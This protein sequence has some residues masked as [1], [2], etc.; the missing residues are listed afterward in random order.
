MKMTALLYTERWYET[1]VCRME[2]F[3]V[4]VVKDISEPGTALE[5]MMTAML[6]VISFVHV[7]SAPTPVGEP[8]EQVLLEVME[9]IR[10]V[11]MIVMQLVITQR[12]PYILEFYSVQT[13][14]LADLV[15]DSR[16]VD[17]ILG[18]F[19][20]MSLNNFSVSGIFTSALHLIKLPGAVRLL[21]D[22]RPQLSADNSTMDY[23]FFKLFERLCATCHRTQA[24]LKSIGIIKSVIEYYADA[25]IRK[26][27]ELLRRPMDLGATS[28][29]PPL[30]GTLSSY[31]KDVSLTEAKTQQ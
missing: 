24:T 21:W 26:D 9:T 19:P 10:M 2:T 20:S 29:R 13:L 27:V 16:T 30:L 18:F 12:T 1:Q 15:A 14:A 25:K 8:G 3:R 7:F 5:M 31:A 28:P 22:F 11:F 4:R 17:V 6:P 23:A